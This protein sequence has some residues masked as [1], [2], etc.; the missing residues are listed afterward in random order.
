M[1]CSAT[2][3]FLVQDVFLPKLFQMMQILSLMPVGEVVRKQVIFCA[4]G[5]G[6]L[7]LMVGCGKGLNRCLFPCS[8]FAVKTKSCFITQLNG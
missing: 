2:L 1:A 4:T 8:L 7:L 3:V 5:C 6:E